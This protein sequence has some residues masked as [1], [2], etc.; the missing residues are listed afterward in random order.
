[1]NSDVL[2]VLVTCP[3]GD[4]AES[5]AHT[6]VEHHEAA[7]VNIVPNLRSVYRWQGRVEMDNELLLLIKTTTTRLDQIRARVRT[8]HP[9]ELPEVIAVPIVA[10]SSAYLDWVRQ[11]TDAR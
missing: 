10:G 8:L 11:E 1:M 2:M 4:T 7:C 9:D 3:D 6:L 5:L